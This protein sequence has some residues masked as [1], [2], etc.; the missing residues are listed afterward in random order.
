[1][2]SLPPRPVQ[3]P[4]LVD[5]DE[6]RYSRD[7]RDRR[8]ARP[9]APLPRYRDERRPDSSDRDYM[10]RRRPPTGDTYIASG[11]DTRRDED[12]DRFRDRDREKERDRERERERERDSRDW[13]RDRDRDRDRNW[14]RERDRDWDRDRDRD[15]DRTRDRGRGDWDRD[16]DRDRDRRNWER[17]R[18]ARRWDDE[19]YRSYDRRPDDDRY[20]PPGSWRDHRSSPRKRNLS[21]RRSSYT[22]PRRRAPSPPT[23]HARA[24]SNPRSPSPNKRIKLDQ[25]DDK[26]GMRSPARSPPERGTRTD[27]TEAQHPNTEKIDVTPP[28]PPQTQT[29]VDTPSQDVIMESVPNPVQ[30]STME[31]E[32][33]ITRSAQAEQLKREEL[34]PLPSTQDRR[35]SPQYPSSTQPTLVRQPTTPGSPMPSAPTAQRSPRHNLER[36]RPTAEASSTA[37]SASTSMSLPQPLV[38]TY[39]TRERSPSPPRRP[40]RPPVQPRSPPRGP[41]SHHHAGNLPPP[42]SRNPSYP[43]TGP[44]GTRRLPPTGPS[45]AAHSSPNV[46]MQLPEMTMEFELLLKGSK[47]AAIAKMKAKQ[48]GAQNT[49]A[50]AD[51]DAEL[52]RS[53]AHRQHL[54]NE[55]VN[56]ISRGVRRALHEVDTS[57]IDLRAAEQ[58]RKVTVEQLE[59]ARAG[60]LGSGSSHTPNEE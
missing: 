29:M 2:A 47:E 27:H 14:G 37:L 33:T 6:R 22:P 13:P 20:R 21:S 36:E 10:S 30:A 41:R 60:V 32:P 35:R 45:T 24:P 44:R 39:R 12:L 51:L 5:R 56:N 52:A 31:R 11:Y 9:M 59:K 23:F 54:A 57:S 42:T 15:R 26:D 49:N 18:D 38:D 28:S 46:P 58:R 3:S 25:P 8:P 16:R 55:Y 50:M 19:R 48:A 40:N 17:D 4:P 7:D 1:M 43:P 34:S 53:Q